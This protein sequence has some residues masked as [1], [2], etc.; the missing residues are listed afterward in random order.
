MGVTSE[1]ATS[2]PG[3]SGFRPASAATLAQILQRQRLEHG[4]VRQVAP[5][6]VGGGDRRRPVH[7]LADRRGLRHLLR[8]HGRRDEP[9]VPAA[10]LGHHAGRA[11]PAAGGGLPP[12]RGPRRPRRRLG[13][14]P[15]VPDPGPAVLHLPR[16]RRDACAVPRRHGVDRA[17]RGPVRRTAGTPCAR[18][19][20]RA[21]SEL[22]IVPPDAELAPWADG[23]AALGRARRRRQA[24]GRAADGD[25]RRLRRA[26]RPPGRP[27]GRRPRRARR[28]RQHAVRL[29]ARR[30][31]RLGR[32][33]PGGHHPRAP[34]RPRHRRRRGRH[35]RADRRDRRRR[36]RTRC[37]RWAGRWP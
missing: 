17:V 37:T 26:R 33:R 14:H 35:E 34:G 22:G 20:S 29:P 19:P 3:Y 5:D 8:L 16:P 27:A 31:R 12:H 2:H 28:A 13:A 24:R 7:P 6:P 25:L 9:L 36:R 23:R 21:R 18:R 32:G 15:A 1:M 11:R 4:R 10:L 30:Q